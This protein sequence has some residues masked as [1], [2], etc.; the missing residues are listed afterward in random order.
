[1]KSNIIDITNKKY[2]V[3]H[4]KILIWIPFGNPDITLFSTNEITLLK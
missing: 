2:I 1:M 4:L 3:R